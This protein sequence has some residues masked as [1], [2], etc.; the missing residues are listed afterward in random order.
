MRAKAAIVLLSV[1]LASCTSFNL[2]ESP[3]SLT[4]KKQR[5]A[6]EAICVVKPFTYEPIKDKESS[7]TSEKPTEDEEVTQADINKWQELLVS[8]LNQSNIFAEVVPARSEGKVDNADYV[9]TGKIRRFY[10]KKNWVPTFF[11]GHIALSFFTLTIYTWAAGPTTVTKVDFEVE[12]T[13]QDAKSGTIIGNFSE[14]YTDT[15]AL[16]IY[17]KG[18]NNPYE[19]PG[20][21]FSTVIDALATKIAAALP[22]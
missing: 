8:G 9:L 15:S 21:V 4:V 10:F 16:N 7:S 1:F 18:I 14:R 19:N 5:R 22:Q 3:L 13:L 12:A 6:K 17:S 11:P 2:A 20:L